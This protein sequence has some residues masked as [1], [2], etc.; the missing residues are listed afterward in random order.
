MTLIDDLQLA[1]LRGIQP[2]ELAEMVADGRLPQPIKRGRRWYWFMRDLT[3]HFDNR[4]AGLPAT[5]EAR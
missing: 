1:A 3:R 5:A 2:G 4:R